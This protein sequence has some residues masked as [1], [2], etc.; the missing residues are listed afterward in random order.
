MGC[1][2]AYPGSH[3]IGRAPSTSGRVE[4]DDPERYRAFIDG[5]PIEQATA[6]EA[7]PGDVLFF[8]YF[9]VH[10]SGPNR[11]DQTRK[12]VLVQLHSGDDRLEDVSNHTVSGL[13]LRGRNR[14]ATRRSVNP[15]RGER[16]GP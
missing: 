8:T 1:I 11:S 3:A 5:Y 4:W 13:V 12:T 7:S 15:G 14:R 9:T 2:R 10:G 6:Y 16:L